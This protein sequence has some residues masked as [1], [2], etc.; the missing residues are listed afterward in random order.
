MQS[1]ALWAS[2]PYQATCF[3]PGNPGP[4]LR[5]LRGPQK[6][7][8]PEASYSRAILGNRIRP[9]GGHVLAEDSFLYRQLFWR[10]AWRPMKA[11]QWGPRSVLFQLLNTMNI[12]GPGARIP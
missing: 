9:N 1:P 5:F 11:T 7:H 4:L 6:H 12:G 2:R 8:A 3:S 10:V